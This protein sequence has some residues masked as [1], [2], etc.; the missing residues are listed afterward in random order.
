MRAEPAGHRIL[1]HTADLALE[2]WAPAKG[3][4]IAEA[5]QALVEGFA[6]VRAVVPGESVRLTFAEPGDED[7]LVRVLDEVIYQLDVHGRL[8]VDISVDVPEDGTP[9]RA[10]VRFA[11]ADAAQAEPTGAVPKAVSRHELRFA[12]DGDLWRCHVTVDT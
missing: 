3:A 4:C 2:A 1:P 5:V 8:P 10:E 9:G 7:L 11:A 6:D 12:R